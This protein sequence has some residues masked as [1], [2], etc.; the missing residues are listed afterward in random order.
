MTNETLDA[1]KPT[2][3]TPSRTRLYAYALFAA[4]GG[5]LFGY[6]TGVVSA[7]IL[8]IRE[9]FNLSSFEQGA[10]VSI[11]LL[12][13][14][15]TAPMAGRVADRYGRRRVLLAVAVIFTVGLALAAIAP[16]LW[17]LLLARLILGIGVGG[18]SAL[19]PVY[20]SEIAPAKIR[21]AL[22]SMNQLMITI[23]LLI[24]Y[25]VGLALS[26]SENW[27][28]MFAAGIICSGAMFVG[29]LLAP[30]TPPWLDRNGHS[31]QAR[32]ILRGYLPESQIT[33]FLQTFKSDE[34][35]GGKAGVTWR[36]L[37][38]TPTIRALLVIGI[39]L[40]VLQQFCG[41]NTIMYYAPTIMENTGLDASNALIY[42]IIIGTINVIMTVIALR[43]T[44]TAGR[45]RLLLISA[46]GMAI[47]TL[48]M[49]LAFTAMTGGAAS[50]TALLSILG[51]IMA[52]AIG[53]GPI[54]WLLNSEIYPPQYRA[55]AAGL[56][57]MANWFANFIVSQSFLPL[58]DAI[59]EGQTFWLFGLVCVFTF[60]FVFKRVPETKNRTVAEIDLDIQRRAGRGAQADYAK[61]A[62]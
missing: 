7:A 54:F 56:G 62:G 33:P 55:A 51:Y 13:A 21:G 34:T 12:S 59:G 36:Q 28:G 40:A 5:I 61:A 22:V 41:I 20:L 32:K 43:L 19:V 37:L 38:A 25:I 44:D 47:A 8:F 23:G 45:R 52:F 15:V 14:A 31:D 9:D 4:L 26:G 29:M 39:G 30:E 2:E 16:N 35:T 27:R 42:S 24:S 53:M 6:D 58:A 49:G 57:T 60:Y 48:P 11:L 3:A 46:G 17:V 18:A 1:P 10:V 50:T